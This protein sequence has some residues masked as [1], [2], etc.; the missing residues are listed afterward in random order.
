MHLIRPVKIEDLDAIEQFANATA[1]G[2][3]NLPRNRNLLKGKIEQS[4]V[5]FSKDVSVAND[6]LYFFALEDISSHKTVGCSAIHART[7]ILE[8]YYFF[9]VE[10]LHPYSSHLPLPS[11]IRVL[12]P[13]LRKNGPSE[14]CSLYLM[15][16]YRKGGLGVLLSKSRLLFIA[17]HLNRFSPQIMA[18]LR[19]FINKKA[20]TSPFWDG[21]GKKFLDISYF[22]TQHLLEHGRGFIPEFLPKYPIY[23]SLLSPQAQA[24]IGQPYSTTYPAMKMLLQEG[25]SST[26]EIDIFDGGPTLQAKTKD[27]RSIKKSY[28]AVI[29]E[30]GEVN[31]SSHFLISNNQLD[32]KATLAKVKINSDKTIVIAKDTA[33]IL[34]VEKGMTIRLA[35]QNS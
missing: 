33:S 11:D 32:F 13:I 10:T 17:G 8:P 19:G 23:V 12:H 35:G 9:R 30:V 34:Q 28:T 15:P 22:E 21:L 7:G 26:Q 5:S 18:S 20:N 24:V 14:L 2:M 16:E 25:F 31:G 29:T 27:V 3:S 4:I 1:L 6:E